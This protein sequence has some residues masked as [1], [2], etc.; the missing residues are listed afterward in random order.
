M[1]RIMNMKKR[2]WNKE[3]INDAIKRVSSQKKQK[4][5]ESIYLESHRIVY[6]TMLLVLLVSN[7]IV[8]VVLVP[9]LVVI[10]TSFV[11]AIVG[12]LGFVFGVLFNHLIRDIENLETHHHLLAV[13]FIPV[14]AL[15]NLFSIIPV[16][17]SIR[18]IL[19]L[20][21]LNNPVIIG[22]VYVLTFIL[23]YVWTGVVEQAKK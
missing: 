18:L 23:P 5:H 6:W 8:A 13:I 4:K 11:Y 14:V 2:G 21:T 12:L 15:L 7:L 22:S 16:T 9:I 20:N 19:D 1:K 17:N 3:E 10:N